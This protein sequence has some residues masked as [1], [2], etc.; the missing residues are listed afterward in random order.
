M[1]EV[2]NFFQEVRQSSG[3]SQFQTLEDFVLDI[4]DHQF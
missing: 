1:V 4:L 3:G 2:K